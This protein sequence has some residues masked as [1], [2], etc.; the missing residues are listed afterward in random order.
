MAAVISNSNPTGDMASSIFIG[1]IAFIASILLLL[2]PVFY[3]F[4]M[5]GNIVVAYLSAVNTFV[6]L[7]GNLYRDI[8]YLYE[9]FF[10]IQFIAMFIG[11]YVFYLTY[12]ST[13]PEK[14][15]QLEGRV[16]LRDDE[17]VDKWR[18]N[19]DKEE[20][21]GEPGILICETPT[22]EILTI[23][24]DR[25]SK[26]AALIGGSGAGKTTILR[27]RIDAARARGDRVIIFD[28]KSDFTITLD[29]GA[30]ILLVAPWD[31]RGWAWDIAA[32]FRNEFDALTLANSIIPES[33]DPMW[34][35]AA[36]AIFKSA[37]MRCQRELPLKWGWSH[38]L[39]ILANDKD[40]K[41]TVDKYQP[42][43]SVLVEDI[44]SKTAQSIMVTMKSFIEPLYYLADAWDRCPVPGRFSLKNWLR[45]EGHEV[46][47]K[48]LIIQGNG[49]FEIIQTMLSQ[50]LFSAIKREITSPTFPDIS[51]PSERRINMFLDEFV[52][53]G[54]LDGFQSFLATGRSKGLRVT[55]AIQD[56]H[57]LYEVYGRD[58]AQTWLSGFGTHII[59]T[60]KGVETTQW[61]SD[62]LGKKRIRVYVPS[63]SS[64]SNS[65]TR[66]DSY[67]E[68][69]RYVVN[70]D[71]F[72]R[73]LGTHGL[74]GRLILFLG[75]DY[76]YMVDAVHL[77]DEIKSQ[78]RVAIK[79]ARW[80][81][82]EWPSAY[83]AAI[84]TQINKQKEEEEHA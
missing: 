3:F 59:G 7:E 47:K 41:A 40:I 31:R 78:K 66:S 42:K 43:S 30:D 72:S 6:P 9:A 26:H 52:Q 81:S 55:L 84:A 10:A 50:L 19:M 34:S 39:Q 69:D 18:E 53:M 51:R 38:V 54:K 74:G 28:N 75:D 5:T 23:S 11:A 48:T 2:L 64:D 29:N 63:F 17:A 27:P 70:P 4:N 82:P 35:K 71:Q 21:W 61:L 80:T 33:K 58:V 32:D 83:D 62:M 12:K 57:Q 76:V 45:A 67:Q 36:V 49:S 46:K 44:T 15:I 37:I 77:S 60:L 73:E 1:F 68:Q 14:E 8:D 65:R 20:E 24:E 79:P 22:G 13:V 16:L 25:E 56:P